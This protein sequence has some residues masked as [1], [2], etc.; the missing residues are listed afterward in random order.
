MERKTKYILIGIVFLLIYVVVSKLNDKLSVPD[1]KY[2]NNNHRYSH[3]LTIR[4]NMPREELENV[5]KAY[6]SWNRKF[7][8]QLQKNKIV[9][10]QLRQF[11]AYPRRKQNKV[12]R[13]F[14]RLV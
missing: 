12:I 6:V 2:K 7:R 3:K 10:G 4:G 1:R 8:P 13:A 5:H 11:A 9:L 14:K